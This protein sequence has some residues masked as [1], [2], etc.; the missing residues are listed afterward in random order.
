MI[1][2]QHPRHPVIRCPPGGPAWVRDAVFA[3]H[4]VL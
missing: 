1:R 2:V 3:A 4:G